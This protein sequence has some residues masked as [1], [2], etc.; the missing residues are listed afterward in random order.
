LT[1]RTEGGESF[2]GQPLGL[3]LIL[4][5]RTLVGATNLGK[6]SGYFRGIWFVHHWSST[7]RAAA[8]L[9]SLL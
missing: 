7:E 1:I 6:D 3:L 2:V 8:V 4:Y 5:L 9:D